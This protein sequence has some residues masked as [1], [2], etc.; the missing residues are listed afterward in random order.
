MFNRPFLADVFTMVSQI[1]QLIVYYTSSTSKIH[2]KSHKT[3]TKNL[4]LN[5]HHT[6]FFFIYVAD[7]NIKSIQYLL[8]TVAKRSSTRGDKQ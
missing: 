1:S 6:S 7:C 5:V 2:I 8:P 4:K 3:T